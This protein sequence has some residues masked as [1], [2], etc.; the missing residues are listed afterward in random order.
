MMKLVSRKPSGILL[1]SMFFTLMLGLTAHAES[2]GSDT[3]HFQLA[4]YAWLAGQSGTVA[5]LPGL[6]PADI[7]I[8]FWDDI[9]G[10]INGAMFLIGEARKDRFGIFMDLAYVNI[11][12]D[13]ATAGPF[14]SSVV[15]TTESWIATG[16]GFY[17]MLEQPGAFL[18]VLAGIR[19][20]S[21]DSTLELRPGL[22]R[23]R[24]V[25]NKEDWVDPIVGLKGLTSLGDS[26]FYLSG[27]AAIGGFGAGSDFMWDV[28]VNL[29]Y[30]WT[31]TISTTIGYRYL[32][33]DYEDDGF[34][35]DVA[36]D[37]PVLGLSWRF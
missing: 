13:S 32:D 36:Q 10:N 21:V 37:G 9:L 1:C 23:G 25:S 22:L 4:P 24:E 7:D 18:D 2:A 16:A 31:E 26:R 12:D 34:L 3:W 8:D 14:F 5:T 27:G 33:V 35:Y 17:R 28:N 11:E 29:G 6:P 20:W 30:R 19:Y 15:S